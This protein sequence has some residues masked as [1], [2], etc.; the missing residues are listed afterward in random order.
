[1]PW[2]WGIWAAAVIKEGLV[3]ASRGLKVSMA[4]ISPVSA[5]TTVISRNCSS[6][7]LL[8]LPSLGLALRG[9]LAT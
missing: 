3:V 8:I 6:R 2:Y 1:M 9:T 7:L 5:T 4:L